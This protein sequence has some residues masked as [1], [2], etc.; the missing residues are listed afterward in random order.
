MACGIL[1]PQPG[2]GTQVPWAQSL[3][4]TTRQVPGMVLTGRKR[5]TA[6]GRKVAVE[7]VTASKQG[8]T[9]E[10]LRN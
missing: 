10:V 7:V 4:W 8:R 2:D 9:Q 1:V 6:K 3:H 5:G